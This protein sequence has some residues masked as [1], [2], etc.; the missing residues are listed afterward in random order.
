MGGKTVL[1]VVAALTVHILHA[2]ADINADAQAV[3][4][5]MSTTDASVAVELIKKNPALALWTE[6]STSLTLLVYACQLGIPSV[7]QTLVDFGANIEVRLPNIL[8]TPLEVAVSES[9]C[10]DCINTL[11][12]AG[13]N[14]NVQDARGLT[15]L[16]Y[17]ADGACESAVPLLMEAGANINLADIHGL[18]V[19]MQM[20]QY[21]SSVLSI[22]LAYC[23]DLTLTDKM[24]L[25]ALQI[26]LQQG[27]TVN[28]GLIQDKLDNM[29]SFGNANYSLGSNR[30][31]NC[32]EMV[33]LK[34]C[35]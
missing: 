7:V 9:C 16:M 6:S 15:A 26:M 23:P 31:E 3:V 1:L 28:A 30:T 19:V 25:T 13:S 29:C 34:N 4:T 32:T 12:K 14:V 17:G 22:L 21:G 35:S 18:T 11:I 5:A 8:T 33:C 10:I 27:L 2:H 24:G 20:K